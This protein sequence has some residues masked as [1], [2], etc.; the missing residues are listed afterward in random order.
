MRETVGN[1]SDVNV[2]KLVSIIPI[3]L[4][5]ARMPAGRP[6]RP[7]NLQSPLPHDDEYSFLERI[8]SR[9]D[10]ALPPLGKKL[11]SAEESFRPQNRKIKWVPISIQMILDSGVNLRIDQMPTCAI[12]MLAWQIMIEGGHFLQVDPRLY[13]R[14]D[15]MSRTTLWLHEYAYLVARTSGQ[16]DSR[17]TREIVATLLKASGEIR[18]RELASL[19]QQL[20]FIT[21]LE[22]AAYE[23]DDRF[24]PLQ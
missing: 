4:W 22:A 16:T 23:N 7:A 9:V 18:I 17:A 11:R 13:E 21:P 2:G 24:Y 15:L 6:P 8:L 19:A 14:M 20:R 5:F 3:D 1:V 10:Q 12:S